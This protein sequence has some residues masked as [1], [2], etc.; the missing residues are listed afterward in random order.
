VVEV[1]DIAR[2]PAL[3][4][5]GHGVQ[6][7]PQIVVFEG[8]QLVFVL[9]FDDFFVFL[10]SILLLLD[11]YLILQVQVSESVILFLEGL[12]LQ[13]KRF[14]SVFNDFLV[15]LQYVVGIDFVDVVLVV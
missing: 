14:N 10:E 2:F 15:V 7:Q 5:G 3:E 13:F 11:F 9:D 4:G 8:D 1:A 12:V 6:L